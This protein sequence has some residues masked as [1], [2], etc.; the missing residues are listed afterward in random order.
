[1]LIGVSL[2]LIGLAYSTISEQDYWHKTESNMAGLMIGFGILSLLI[3]LVTYLSNK[4]KFKQVS[5]YTRKRIS[6]EIKFQ[7][8]LKRAQLHALKRGKVKVELKGKM[9]KLR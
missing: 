4:D 2:L 7:D 5:K 6:K 9:R 3:S 8:E 1:M